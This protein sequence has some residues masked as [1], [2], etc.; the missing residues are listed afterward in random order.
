MFKTY[1]IQPLDEFSAAWDLTPETTY[2]G[3]FIIT[4]ILFFF[5]VIILTKISKIFISIFN[6]FKIKKD[7]RDKVKAKA[8]AKLEL[9]EITPIDFNRGEEAMDFL[10]RLIRDKYNYYLYLELLPVYLDSRIP[11]RSVIRKIKEKIYVSVVGSLTRSVKL[12]LLEFFTEK[13]IEI[14]VNQKIVIMMNMTD[15][16]ASDKLSESFRE[17]T[18]KNIDVLL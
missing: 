4:L 9:G 8:K 7:R 3:A 10:D 2:L 11:E 6:F 16:Q 14:Y 17:I 18:V 15:F 12:Q 13:G 5:S 1:S